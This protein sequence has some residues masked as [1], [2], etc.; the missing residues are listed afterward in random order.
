MLY[1]EFQWSK[2]HTPWPQ[3]QGNLRYF[4]TILE[5]IKKIENFNLVYQ[6]LW[7]VVRAYVVAFF[8]LRAYFEWKVIETLNSL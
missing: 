5:K 2:T 8:M 1:T 6:F 3:N 7:V 4:D